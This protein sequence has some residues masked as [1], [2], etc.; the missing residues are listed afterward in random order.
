MKDIY[1]LYLLEDSA[2]TRLKKAPGLF[3]TTGVIWPLGYCCQ[4]KKAPGLFGPWVIC[5][6]KT[7]GI[8]QLKKCIIIL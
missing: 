6:L 5:A 4:I 2:T 8:K 7:K 1:S 3:D